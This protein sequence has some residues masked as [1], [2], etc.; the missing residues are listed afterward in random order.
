MGD[1]ITNRGAGEGE[2][3]RVVF[4]LTE[5]ELAELDE[6]VEAWRAEQADPSWRRSRGDLL[7]AWMDAGELPPHRPQHRAD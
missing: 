7:R 6:L 2:R 3:R 1:N 4:M 5:R